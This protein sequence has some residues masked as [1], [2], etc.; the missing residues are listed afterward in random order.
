MSFA[1]QVTGCSSAFHCVCLFLYPNLVFYPIIIPG[2]DP[3]WVELNIKFTVD[4][5]KKGVKLGLFPAFVRP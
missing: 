4:V 1:E 3:D 5:F 2:R